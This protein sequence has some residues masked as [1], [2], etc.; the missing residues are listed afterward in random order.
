MIAPFALVRAVDIDSAVAALDA[1]SVPY[2]GGTELLLAMKM[3]LLTPRRL[4]D[5][6][7]VPQLREVAV[8]GSVLFVGAGVTHDQAA[9]HP[10]VAEH[11]PLLA[12]V[13]RNVGNARVRSQG[14]LGGNLCFAEPRSDL[15]TVLAA[16]GGDVVLR[17]VGGERRLTAPDFVLGPYWTDR[18]DG[19]LLVGIEIPLPCAAGSYLKLQLAER[20]TVGVAAVRHTGPQPC[21]LVVGAATATPQLFT[22]DDW[23]AVDAAAVAGQIEPVDDLA[24]SAEYKRHVTEIYVRRVVATV[25]ERER[26]E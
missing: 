25:M 6:K 24:G 13:E 20:P 8:R 2:A 5:L 14:T 11:A 19:E 21:R 10:L 3:G 1:D 16:V 9:R 23:T 15:I 17:S 26:G 12:E 22:Y 18:G 4:V 7:R